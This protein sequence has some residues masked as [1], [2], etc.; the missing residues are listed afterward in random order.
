[1]T[2]NISTR[3]RVLGIAYMSYRQQISKEQR[4]GGQKTLTLMQDI[5]KRIPLA[6]SET[7]VQICIFCKVMACLVP[8]SESKA[9]NVG[10]SPSSPMILNFYIKGCQQKEFWSAQSAMKDITETFLHWRTWT[11]IC[12]MFG[13]IGRVS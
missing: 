3:G 2:A 6:C 10:S 13:S 7:T 9:E 4:S 12:L 1:M 11:G 5:I 8:T